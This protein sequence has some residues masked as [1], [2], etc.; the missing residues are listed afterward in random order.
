MSYE[1]SQRR[2]QAIWD[3]I[4]EEEAQ[5]EEQR[6]FDQ[7]STS[8][9]FEDDPVSDEDLQSEHSLHNTDTEQSDS[10]D[11]EIESLQPRPGTSGLQTR[12]SGVYPFP[13][14]TGKDGT[15]WLVHKEQRRPGKTARPNI[16]SQLPGV[17]GVAKNANTILDAWKLFFPDEIIEHITYCTNKQLEIM[18]ASYKEEKHCLPTDFTE[19]NAFLGLL[20]MAGVKKA[21]H[22]NTAELWS[23]DGTAPEY[24]AAT[25]PKFRF[26]T[27]VRAIRFDD[28]ET[29]TERAKQDNLAPIRY[30]VDFFTEKCVQHYSV[31]A[32]IT[33]DEMLEAFRGKCKF[34]QYIA[35]KPAKYG[36]KIYAVVDSRMFYTHNIEIYAGKQPDGPYKVSNDAQSVVLRL[37]RHCSGTGRNVTADNFFSS[38]PLA[39]T[40]LDQHR[41]TYVGTL[42]KNKREIPPFFVNSKTRPLHSSVFAWGVGSNKCMITSYVPKKYKNVLLLS[43]FHGDDEIDPE[44][45]E[46]NKPSV[47]TFYNLTKGGV[48][49]VDRMKTEYSVTRVSNRWPLTVFS[50][51]LNIGGINSQIIYYTNTNHKIPRRTYLTDLA[52]ALTKPHLLRRSGIPNLSIPLRQ[53]ITNCLG[54]E[55][56]AAAP[57]PELAEQ[58]QARPPKCFFCPKKKSRYTQ[59]KCA[60]C[61]KPICKEHTGKTTLQCIECVNEDE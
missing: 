36:I 26:H 48:D 35:N 4:F 8:Q 6:R 33:I 20:Y 47:I 43:T 24:F 1:E 11:D 41:L 15:N 58:R 38:I 37:I 52:K 28:K 2:L 42:R 55:T 14:Y 30:I 44:S 27:L 59:H 34:R 17:R 57:V 21:Q 45:G 50:S 23:T 49:V 60:A 19:M 3:K 13:T 54:S 16:V 56:P 31:G 32:Y 22:L 39:N 40:L 9:P 7:P 18:R 46:L 12:Q 51:L 53:K 25:M 61:S 10:D 5:E 29:R